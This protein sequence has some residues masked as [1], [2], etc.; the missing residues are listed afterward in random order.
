M[1]LCSTQSLELTDTTCLTYNLPHL[2]LDYT[3]LIETANNNI[4]I[5]YLI[6]NP[7]GAPILRTK[8]ITIN[9]C[10]CA[11]SPPTLD[12]FGEEVVSPQFDLQEQSKVVDMDYS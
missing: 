3:Y 9:G 7:E 5:L 11:L 8:V 10:V 4:N 2:F 6:L 12:V 1:H